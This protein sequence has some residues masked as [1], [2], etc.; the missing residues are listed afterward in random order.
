MLITYLKLISIIYITFLKVTTKYELEVD[1]PK[2]IKT[3]FPL[4]LTP[5]GEV[6]D[7]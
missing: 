6:C 4:T 1:L 2:R 7:S 5:H 3:F